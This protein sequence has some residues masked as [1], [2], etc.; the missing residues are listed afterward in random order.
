MVKKGIQSNG[1]TCYA[2]Q[3]GNGRSCK[4]Y[5]RRI[6][7]DEMSI[8]RLTYR[9]YEGWLYRKKKRTAEKKTA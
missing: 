5:G 2:I 7:A 3:H 6:R 4:Q 8:L 1:E 9:E